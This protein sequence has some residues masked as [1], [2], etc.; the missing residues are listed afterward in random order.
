MSRA[1]KALKLCK[2]MN[3]TFN[4]FLLFL[5]QTGKQIL[6]LFVFQQVFFVKHYGCQTAEK[7]LF[8]RMVMNE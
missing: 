6:F 3:N 7:G 5:M 8:L 4:D 1:L 2:S